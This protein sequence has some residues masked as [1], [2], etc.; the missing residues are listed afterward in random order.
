MRQQT[1][2]LKEPAEK[3]VQDIR[4]AT[5]KHYSAEEK[6]RIVLEGLRGEDSIAELCRREGIGTTASSAAPESPIDIGQQRHADHDC[7]KD[8]RVRHR[9]R[10]VTPVMSATLRPDS[11]TDPP[12]NPRLSFR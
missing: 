10:P 6:V 12:L 11:A 9:Q 4:R 2:A 3:V 5:R 7:H 1:R 8:C